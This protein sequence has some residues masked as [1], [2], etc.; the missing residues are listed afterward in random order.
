MKILVF[1]KSGQ[2]GS[3]LFRDFRENKE[4]IFLKKS[5]ADFCNPDILKKIIF[6]IKPKVIINAAAYTN[7]D[8][9]EKRET[10]HS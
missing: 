10:K 7:V 6:E 9:A 2:L 5:E 1:G 4:F 8:L 3:Q